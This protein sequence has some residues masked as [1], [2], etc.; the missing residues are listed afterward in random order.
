MHVEL[1][2]IDLGSCPYQIVVFVEKGP[3]LEC[4]VSFHLC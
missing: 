3:Y 1:L 4:Q 2:K